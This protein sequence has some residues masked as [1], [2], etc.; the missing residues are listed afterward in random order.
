MSTIKDRIYEIIEAKGTNA[1]AFEKACGLSN[2]YLKSVKEDVGSSK[3]E[4]ILRKFK[5]ISPDWLILGEGEMLRKDAI[6]NYQSAQ[7]AEVNQSIVNG[8]PCPSVAVEQLRMKDEQIRHLQ[9]QTAS[10][11][12]MLHYALGLS[13]SPK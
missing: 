6:H 5:D 3:L 7:G 10:L 9:A 2:G 4:M 12:E 13:K 8:Q 1:Y 11:T